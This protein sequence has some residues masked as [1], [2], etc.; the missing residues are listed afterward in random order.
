MIRLHFGGGVEGTLR[1]LKAIPKEC[2]R[3][4]WSDCVRYLEKLKK[5]GQKYW[6]ECPTP[7]EID[8]RPRCPGH[9]APGKSAV[10]EPN[11]QSLEGERRSD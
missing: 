6:T 2:R 5:Q 1:A 10:D 3:D 7:V 11:K 9:P 8:G 4:N